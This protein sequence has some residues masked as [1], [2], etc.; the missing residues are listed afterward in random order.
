LDVSRVTSGKVTLAPKPVDLRE[1]ISHAVRTHDAWVEGRHMKVVLSLGE[2][3]AMVYGDP[4]RLE[5]IVVNL[6][7]NALKYTQAGGRVDVELRLDRATNEHVL[8]VRD[9]GVGIEQKALDR[10]FEL[11]AQVDGTLDRSQGGIGLGLTLV[12]SLLAMH[13][14]SIV[15]TS[16][17][18]GMGSEF[19]ARLPRAAVHPVEEPEA[20][21]Q[22]ETSARLDVVLV[23]D[24]IDIREMMKELLED[25]GHRVSVAA[26]GSSGLSL[27]LE[28]APDLAIV[29]I[30][31]PVLDG[32]QVAKEARARG[33]SGRMLAMTGYGQPEDRTR[34]E[35]AGFDAHLT[36]PVDVDALRAALTEGR[37]G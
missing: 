7:G 16:E 32:Y 4:A 2:A 22:H 29:D 37:A 18:L 21:V 20:R 30:G 36:K 5:Q 10:I 17:G 14:G 24:N 6:V 25:D 27:I 34:A 19:I 15:A 3:P 28:K 33:H 13:G 1:V 8:K 23:E 11:F 9:T 35:Q 12:R 26:D 31:L